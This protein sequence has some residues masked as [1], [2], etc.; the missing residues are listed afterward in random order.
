MIDLR[1]YISRCIVLHLCLDDDGDSGTDLSS[2]DDCIDKFVSSSSASP[3]ATSTSVSVARDTRL[4]VWLTNTNGTPQSPIDGESDVS[5]PS[6]RASN[7]KV[8]ASAAKDG[9]LAFVRDPSTQGVRCLVITPRRL[10]PSGGVDDSGE[11]NDNNN[12]GDV[13]DGMNATGR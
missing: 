8:S 4:F 1:K 10:P 11:D 3:T 12:Y 5:L 13:N 2:I 6:L 7:S 9:L